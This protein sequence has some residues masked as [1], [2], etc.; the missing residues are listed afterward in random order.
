MYRLV[1]CNYLSLLHNFIL[2]YLAT[3]Y[4][5]RQTQAR[6][7][8]SIR[9]VHHK[10]HEFLDAIISQRRYE[11]VKENH[12][13]EGRRRWVLRVLHDSWPEIVALEDGVEMPASD[14]ILTVFTIFCIERIGSDIPFVPPASLRP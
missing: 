6:A 2:T 13:N 4:G 3:S 7:C 8:G 10:L 5:S 11:S 9:S 1:K 12:P 14:G